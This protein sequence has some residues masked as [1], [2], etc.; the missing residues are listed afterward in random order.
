MWLVVACAAVWLHRHPSY[1]LAAVCGEVWLKCGETWLRCGET[2]VRWR[3][4][5]EEAEGKDK[6]M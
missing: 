3:K 5:A 2:S 4:G 1:S 6:D